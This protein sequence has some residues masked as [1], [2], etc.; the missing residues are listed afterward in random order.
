MFKVAHYVTSTGNDPVQDYLDRMRDMQA[1]ISII[2]RIDRAGMGNFGDHRVNIREGV[3]ELR[4]DVGKGYRVYY[5]LFQGEM[6]L[7]LLCAGDKSTQPSDI[8]RAVHY[9]REYLAR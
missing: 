4:I 2:R 8:D 6:L 7:L 3:S 5:T 9:R 1:R